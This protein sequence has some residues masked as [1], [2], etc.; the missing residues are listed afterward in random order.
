MSFPFADEDRNLRKTIMA[1]AREGFAR[2]GFFGTSLDSIV[3]KAGVSK[4]AIYWHF[5]GKWELYKAVL[6]EEVDRI[7]RVFIPPGGEL[8]VPPGEDFFISRGNLLIDALAEDLEC[9]L[10][11]VHL[12]LEAMRGGSG[13]AEFVSSLRTSILQDAAPLFGSLFPEEVLRQRGIS[14]E[15][16]MDMFQSV[17]NGFIM[18]LG[19][20]I[21]REDAKQDWRF[22][23]SCVLGHLEGGARIPRAI[24]EASETSFPNA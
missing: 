1:A 9:R 2:R 10:L 4:G 6:S 22:L 20:T 3:K 21:T 24:P 13:M 17:L 19:L 18:N 7:K 14:M 15:R 11:F 8:S 23:V 16:L 5:P 12:C